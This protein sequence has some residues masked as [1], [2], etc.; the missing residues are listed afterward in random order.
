V[1][2][3]IGG[4]TGYIVGNES[5]KKKTAQQTQQQINAAHQ[6]QNIE[7]V[8]I[9]LSNGSQ[10]PIKLTR[11]GPNYIGPRGEFYS[12]MP[13]EEQLKVLYGF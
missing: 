2:A 6:E 8:W 7:T 9:T 1:G 11:S 3:A 12:T 13:T 10:R 5:D 4:G